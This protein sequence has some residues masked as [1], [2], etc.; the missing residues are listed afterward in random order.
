M[1]LLYVFMVGTSFKHFNNN[2][3]FKQMPKLVKHQSFS[4]LRYVYFF[5]NITSHTEISKYRMVG[6]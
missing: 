1:S 4:H 5:R 3:L 6:F 2:D